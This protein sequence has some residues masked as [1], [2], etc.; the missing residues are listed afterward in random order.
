MVNRFSSRVT[1]VLPEEALTRVSREYSE[2][3]TF[4]GK[5]GNKF[6]KVINSS[7]ICLRSRPAKTK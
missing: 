7:E 1:D 4:R 3:E 5:V 6:C 2:D